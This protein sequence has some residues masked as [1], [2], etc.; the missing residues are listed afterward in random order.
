[1][2]HLGRTASWILAAFVGGLLLGPSRLD[3]SASVPGWFSDVLDE[4]GTVE[5]QP[6]AALY[7]GQVHVFARAVE[8]GLR[9]LWH[10]GTW[11]AETLDIAESSGQELAV[12]VLGSQ[13]QVFN[14][15]TSGVG[16][17]HLWYDE[18]WKTETLDDIPSTGYSTTVWTGN[19]QLQLFGADW[20]TGGIRHGWY[21]GKWT[22]ETLD[23]VVPRN[24]VVQTATVTYAANGELQ[25]FASFAF[26]AIRH[27]WYDGEWHFE[28]QPYGAGPTSPNNLVPTNFGDQLHLFATTLDPGVD[29]MWFDGAWHGEWLD[30]G[31]STGAG[32]SS[33]VFGHNGQLQLFDD[34]IGAAG[35]RHGWYDG[36]WNFETL[37]FDVSAPATVAVTAGDRLDVFSPASGG[38]LLRYTYT[39]P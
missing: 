30:P 28:S 14:R 19:G 13:L 4:T 12:T 16:V 26:G 39:A 35:L 20:Q 2:R 21:D 31:Q 7:R 34:A 6:A 32:L 3:A 5:S 38:G 29:H 24:P 27:G 11:Q 37:P 36:R 17:R 33:V 18:T 9:H 25:V 15:P 22:F 1:M 10:D 23:D 8:G